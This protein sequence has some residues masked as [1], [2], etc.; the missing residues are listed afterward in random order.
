M[1]ITTK[2]F[3]IKVLHIFNVILVPACLKEE[4]GISVWCFLNLLKGDSK[5]RGISVI[6]VLVKLYIIQLIVEILNVN[7][8]IDLEKKNLMKF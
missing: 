2:L 1:N 6:S 8:T 3:L 5:Y 4:Y 7:I